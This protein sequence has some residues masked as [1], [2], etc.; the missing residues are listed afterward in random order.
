M[1]AADFGGGVGGAVIDHD[2]FSLRI[3]LVQRRQCAAQTLRFVLGRQ[4]DADAFHVVFPDSPAQ[5]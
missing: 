1:G 5:C 4:D 3:E 2:E